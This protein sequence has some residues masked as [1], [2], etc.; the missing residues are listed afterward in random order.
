MAD[1]YAVAIFTGISMP[2]LVKVVG[3]FKTSDDA[4]EWIADQGYADREGTDE[5]GIVVP[6]RSLD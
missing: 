1:V 4:E 5:F 2:E 3:P 6:M